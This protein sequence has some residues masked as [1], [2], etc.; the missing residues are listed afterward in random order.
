VQVRAREV[1]HALQRAGWYVDRQRGHVIMR[2]PER[3]GSVSIPIH[4]GRPLKQGTLL[5][6]LRVAGINEEQLR[7]LL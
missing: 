4:G 6:I 3:P 5:H 2:H 7:E 1:I